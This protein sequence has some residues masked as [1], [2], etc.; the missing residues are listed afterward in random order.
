[1]YEVSKSFI[2]KLNSNK[3]PGVLELMF[4]GTFSSVTGQIVS[5]PMH[6]VKARLIMQGTSSMP[7]RFSGTFDVL[8]K[9]ISREGFRGLYKGLF[10]SL[11]KSIPSNCI[12]WV[13]YEYS[14]R[15]LH[16]DKSKKHH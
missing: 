12:T 5:Y 15:L 16:I 1:M 8:K 10:P 14:K 3:A 9:T 13:V 2:E 4:C 11:L 7:E 6:V